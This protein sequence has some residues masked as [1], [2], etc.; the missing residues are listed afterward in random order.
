MSQVLTAFRDVAR[1]NRGRRASLSQIA[2][3]TRR[4][5]VDP[6]LNGG[7]ALGVWSHADLERMARLAQGIPGDF[8]EIGVF[9]GRAFQKV[10]RLASAQNKT[11]HAFDSFVG[12]NDPGPWDGTEYPKGEFDIGGPRAFASMMAARGIPSQTYQLH[13]GYI[14]DC[15]D[16]VDPNLKFS[17][18]ILDVDHYEPTR[19]G[20]AWVWPRVNPSGILALDDFIFNRNTLATRA[21][22]EFLRTQDDFDPIA[23]FNQQL[24]LRKVPSSSPADR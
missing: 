1:G 17:L 19:D 4:K 9:R 2:L 11:A 18:V 16:G 6:V 8:A 20:L 15:F 21:I 10:A 12:M 23:C 3:L 22:K 24:I 5:F 7:R 14:P 13:P